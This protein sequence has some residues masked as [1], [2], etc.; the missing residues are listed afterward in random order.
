M[1]ENAESARE[2]GEGHA[3]EP[4][5]PLVSDSPSV[6]YATPGDVLRD[7]ALS[8]FEKR[9][10]LCRWALDAYRSEVTCSKRH[11]IARPSNLDEVIDALI[12]LDEPEI[13]RVAARARVSDC[14]ATRSAA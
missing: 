6:R 1:R 7:P 3:D 11:D 2:R 8:E 12:D 4:R 5:A 10:V 9:N 13:R 14:N